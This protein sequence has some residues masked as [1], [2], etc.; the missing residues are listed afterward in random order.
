LN[1][2]MINISSSIKTVSP[3]FKVDERLVWIEISGLPLCAWGSNAFKKVASLFGKFLFF[4]VEQSTSM[5][6]GRICISTK[7]QQIMSEKVKVEIYGEIFETLVHEIGTWSINI[8]NESDTLSTGDE[9]KVDKD[10]TS[11]DAS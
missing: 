1:V 8:V 3:S 7:L 9:N 6:M 10:V 5:G 11:S 2:I 4:E